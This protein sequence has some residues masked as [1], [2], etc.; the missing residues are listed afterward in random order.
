MRDIHI[1]AVGVQMDDAFIAQG[2]CPGIGKC[3]RRR[4]GL[5][6]RGGGNIKRRCGGT[7]RR[8]QKAVPEGR[9]KRV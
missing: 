6:Q 2:D 5:Q 3:R 1:G 7:A 9:R 4:R 8:P